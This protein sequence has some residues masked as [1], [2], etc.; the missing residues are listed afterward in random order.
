M[1]GSPYEVSVSI[2]QSKQMFGSKT[3]QLFA[4]YFI[5]LQISYRVVLHCGLVS[6]LL[7]GTM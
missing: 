5:R 3:E 1:F 2:R 7:K 6:D 4:C